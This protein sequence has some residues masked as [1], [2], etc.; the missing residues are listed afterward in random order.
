MDRVSICLGGCNMF[1]RVV[2]VFVAILS[3]F[4]IFYSSKNMDVYSDVA[5]VAKS[6][7]VDVYFTNVETFH[8][9]EASL[10]NDGKSI[11]LDIR[12]V[13]DQE[14]VQYEVF[15]NSF[16]YDTEIEILVN[17]EEIDS[18][19]YFTIQSESFL[20]KSGEVKSGVITIE[21]KK[22]INYPLELQLKAVPM[23]KDI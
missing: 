5:T 3:A 22:S 9:T 12:E 15:N 13:G 10:T 23:K 19:E 21:I 14:V 8:D 16:S 7:Y 11:L 1:E 2:C 18:N 4:S 20:L 17:G 6:N